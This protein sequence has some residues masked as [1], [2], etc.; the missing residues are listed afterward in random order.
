MAVDL[1]FQ[2]MVRI[3]RDECKGVVTKFA[4]DAQYSL[5]VEFP[6]ISRCVRILC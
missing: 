6:V 1:M 2:V 4:N 5:T 3:P